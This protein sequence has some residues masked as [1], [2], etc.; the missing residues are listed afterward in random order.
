[1]TVAVAA[2]VRVAAVA[3]ARAAAVVAPAAAGGG[4]A[5]VVAAAAAAVAARAAEVVV[6]DGPFRRGHPAG[7]NRRWIF[8]LGLAF[9]TTK[10]CA[11]R[12]RPAWFSLG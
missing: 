12:P 2:A 10:G 3:V 6:S 4:P 9:G 5:A 1:M 11:L 7:A 8:V